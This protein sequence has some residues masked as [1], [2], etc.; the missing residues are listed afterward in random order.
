MGSQ[1]P[2]S[3]WLTP[4][5][6]PALLA[7]WRCFSACRVPAVVSNGDAG[8]AALSRGRCSSWKQKSARR[9]KCPSPGLGPRG[10]CQ[11]HLR[12]GFSREPRG[13][14]HGMC[15]CELGGS[16]EGDWPL[17]LESCPLCYLMTATALEGTAHSCS[18]P[19]QIL[20]QQG[21]AWPPVLYPKTRSLGEQS[22]T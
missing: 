15:G 1:L 9:S 21:G 5:P 13:P 20:P 19:P 11:G 3:L 18:S 17:G 14:P 4:A 16:S 10:C 2:L 12:V 22:Q 6:S 7:H 8:D